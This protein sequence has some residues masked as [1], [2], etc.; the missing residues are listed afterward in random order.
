M[1]LHPGEIKRCSPVFLLKINMNLIPV[2]LSDLKIGQPLLWDLFD[3]EREPLMKRGCIIETDNAL[4]ALSRKSSIFL[5]SKALSEKVDSAD[6]KISDFDF[7]DMQL[8]IGEKLYLQRCAS[9]KISRWSNKDDYSMSTIIG[10]VPNQYLIVS[11]PKTNQ[12]I[13]Q[14]F[15]EGDQISVRLFS[16]RCVFSFIVFVDKLVNLSFKYLLLS[17]PKNIKGLTIRNSRRVKTEIAAEVMVNS[18]S[19]PITITN[20][21]DTGAE[22]STDTEL[23]KFG[24]KMGLFVKIRIHETD[25]LLQ[26]QAIVKS[27][28][29]K[30]K[31][32]IS[33]YGIEFTGLLADQIFSLRSFI[34]QELVE[35]PKNSI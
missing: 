5:R 7:D 24:T 10:Y 32:G 11:M 26:L 21:S 16:G 35:N 9:G 30:N 20:L 3:Q 34:Y 8:K 1:N 31:H 14:A 33:R 25:V 27:L 13:G 19:V 4:E 6:T 18:E 17:F 23:G 29:A 12:L 28:K 2:Q 15:L 22:I